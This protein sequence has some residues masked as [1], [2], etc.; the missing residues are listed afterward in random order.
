MMGTLCRMGVQNRTESRAIS[1]EILTDAN[2]TS[3]GACAQTSPFKSRKD[4]DGG[5][6]RG[7]EGFTIQEDEGTMV[8]G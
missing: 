1:Y 7:R 3:A 5:K 6:R 2:A 8:M 4:H